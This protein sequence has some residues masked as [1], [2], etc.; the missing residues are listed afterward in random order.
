MENKIEEEK[1][2]VNYTKEEKTLNTIADV[3]LVLGVGVALLLLFFKST[4]FYD[5]G[6]E[7]INWPIIIQAITIGLSSLTAWAV[8]KVIVGISANINKIAN[9]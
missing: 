4:H 9:K 3:V 2:Q 7:D 6:N 8:L 5:T 1:I